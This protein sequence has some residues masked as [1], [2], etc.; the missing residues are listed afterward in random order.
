MRIILCYLG[1]FVLPAYASPGHVK[2]YEH[3]FLGK[4]KAVAHVRV[5]SAN[6]LSFNHEHLTEQCGIN[7]EAVV[8]ET[9]KGKVTKDRI[10]FSSGFPLYVGEEY[11]LYMGREPFP[12]SITVQLMP[13][14]EK[15]LN[16]CKKGLNTPDLDEWDFSP[17]LNFPGEL[18]GKWVEIIDYGV[19][20]KRIKPVKAE[21]ERQSGECYFVKLEEV[22]RRAK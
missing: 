2:G 22:K 8:I 16:E 18:E 11:V 21:C 19:E 13:D 10:K 20:F 15:V 5:I 1:A 4:S 3:D 14:Y 6:E 9:F 12:R 17:I 7:Y